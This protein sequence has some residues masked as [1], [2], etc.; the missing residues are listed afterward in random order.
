MEIISEKKTVSDVIWEAPE[1]IQISFDETEAGPTANTVEGSNY[2][3][4]S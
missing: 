2:F 1:L 4:G 3:I